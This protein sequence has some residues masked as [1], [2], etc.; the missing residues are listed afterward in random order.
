MTPEAEAEILQT[1]GALRSFVETTG[2]RLEK[3]EQEM[4]RVSKRV[5]EWAV[6]AKMFK[7]AGAAVLCLLTFRFGD[8]KGLFN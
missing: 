7:I 3:M 6:V 1:I 8:V 4:D 5:D 2:P